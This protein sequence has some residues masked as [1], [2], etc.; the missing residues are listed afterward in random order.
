MGKGG[1]GE[2]H[3]LYA[4]S[5]SRSVMTPAAPSTDLKKSMSRASTEAKRA[6]RLVSA[7]AAEKPR[8][9]ADA[10]AAAADQVDHGPA[11]AAAA[12]AAAAAA[13]LRGGPHHVGTTRPARLCTAGRCH[14]RSRLRARW[15]SA[16]ASMWPMCGRMRGVCTTAAVGEDRGEE[17]QGGGGAGGRGRR[18]GSSRG[19]ERRQQG[20][21]MVRCAGSVV[22]CAGGWP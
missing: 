18:R 13:G 22:E 6:S 8:A 12:A 15:P 14:C 2:S 3:V 17:G 7:A 11:V 21:A 19:E 4:G 10:D 16:L 9:D 20:S 1:G 5:A